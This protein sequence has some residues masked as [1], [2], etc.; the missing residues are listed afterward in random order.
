M[1]LTLAEIV[2]RLGGEVR[3]DAA[4]EVSRIA[5]L[6]NAQQGMIAFL[7]NPKYQ[8]QLAQTQAS[9][10]ILSEAAAAQSPVPC[11]VTPQPY[12]YFARLAQWLNP[13]PR[14]PLGLHASA[15]STSAL[16]PS[17]SIGPGAR[18]GNDVKLGA[19]V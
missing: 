17:V 8:K 9:A 1:E 2:E 18:I 13:A 10:V 7:A 15:T 6:E 11:I 16:P 3:G 12:L 4:T 14:P 19:N 5:T